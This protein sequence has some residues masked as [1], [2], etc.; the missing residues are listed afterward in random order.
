MNE[1]RTFPASG[2][3]N[4]SQPQQL[5]ETL[6]RIERNLAQIK[7]GLGLLGIKACSQCKRFFRSSEAGTLFD[8]GELVCF[9]CIREWWP[10]YSVHLSVKDREEL[11]SKLAYWLREFHHAEVIKDAAKLPEASKQEL[12]IVAT[13]LECHGSGLLMGNERC[14]YCDAR[15]TVWIVVSKKS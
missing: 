7:E 1:T 8:A 10:N 5:D 2:T 9:S 11:E 4:G 6:A 15:G 12:Q 3:A 14:R 13:C